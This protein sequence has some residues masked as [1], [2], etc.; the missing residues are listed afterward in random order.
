MPWGVCGGCCV[1]LAGFPAGQP[2]LLPPL[3]VQEAAIAS[4]LPGGAT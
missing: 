3:A 4:A 2:S 1:W